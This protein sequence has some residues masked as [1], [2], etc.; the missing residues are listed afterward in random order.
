MWEKYFVPVSAKSK[1]LNMKP[2]SLVYARK[3]GAMAHILLPYKVCRRVINI[4]RVGQKKPSTFFEAL[5][6][7]IGNK[8]N[9]DF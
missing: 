9:L 1:F 6:R 5:V 4:Y 3:L 2:F 8:Q 7:K